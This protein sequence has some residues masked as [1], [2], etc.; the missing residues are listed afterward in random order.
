MYKK[1][2]TLRYTYNLEVVE[3][4]RSAMLDNILIKTIQCL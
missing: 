4:I 2:R 1:S 3:E